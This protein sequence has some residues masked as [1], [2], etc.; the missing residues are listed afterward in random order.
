MNLF[1]E[2]SLATTEVIFGFITHHR[3]ASLGCVL[4]E[5][6]YNP[7]I[8]SQPHIINALLGKEGA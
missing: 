7:S 1:A 4:T 8:I 2:F 6:Q 5:F 3:K